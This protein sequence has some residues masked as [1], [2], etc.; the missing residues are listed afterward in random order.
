[1]LVKVRK[2][3]VRKAER[4]NA[5]KIKVH[6]NG[7]KLSGKYYT[8]GKSEELWKYVGSTVS[9]VGKDVFDSK[10]NFVGKVNYPAQKNTI[11]SDEAGCQSVKLYSYED[12][13]C[14]IA[15]HFEAYKKT[16]PLKKSRN[17]EPAEII[18][19]EKQRYANFLWEFMNCVV[20][21]D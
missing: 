6:Y 14:Y 17:S 16:H 15:A 13:R 19:A 1:M 21:Q 18:E 20:C 9:V 8:F 10:G 3:P 11:H 7:I 4:A 2:K 12:I 5:V